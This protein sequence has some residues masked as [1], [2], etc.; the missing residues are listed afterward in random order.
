[1]EQRNGP[2]ALLFDTGPRA[3]KTLAQVA[4]ER[5]VPYPDVLLELG[6]GGG[7][8][9]HSVMDGALQE[10]LLLDPHV[11]L[12]SDGS[13]GL[14]HP[15]SA[16]TFARFIEEFAVRSARLPLEEAVRKATSL[17]ASILRLADRGIVREGAFADLVLFD[18]AR[19]RARAYYVDPHA[20]AEGFDLVIVNGEPAFES[21]EAVGRPGRLLRHAGL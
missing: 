19:V 16:G 1:M 3:G 18:P 6:P 4:A 11:A 20:W 15:R 12:G 13:P 7:S 21:G 8:A 2:E 5:G 17:P 14:R 9:A 10:R